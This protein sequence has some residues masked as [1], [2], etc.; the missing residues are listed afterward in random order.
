MSVPA[1]V[2]RVFRF[3][4]RTFDVIVVDTILYPPQ[5]AVIGVSLLVVVAH[6]FTG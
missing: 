1:P 2:I 4:G 3:V 6:F 5:L